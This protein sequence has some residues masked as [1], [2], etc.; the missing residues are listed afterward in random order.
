MLA[1][2]STTGLALV[3]GL[4]GFAPPPA[5]AHGDYDGDHDIDNADFA[6]LAGC[7]AGPGAGLGSGCGAFD[8]D[9]DGD[10]DLA[11]FAVFQQ[12]F[13]TAPMVSVPG[14]SFWMGDP[15]G[16]GDADEQPAH[17]VY[18]SPYYIDTYEVTNQQYVAA[19]NWARAQGALITV[20]DGRVYRY[21]G[22]YLYCETT[23][24]DSHSRITWDPN[25]DT[26]GL[27]PGKESHPIL[28]VSWYGAVA[29]CNWRSAMEGKPLCYNLSTW[30]CTFPLNGYRLPTEAEWEKAAAWDPVSERHYRFGEHTDG[31]GVDCLDGHR[32]NYDASGDPYE[33]PSYPDTTPV[34]F[35]NGALHYK[36][37][38]GWPA[39]PT[40]YQT[41]DAQSYYGC[42][43]MSGNVREWC[44]DWY[45]DTYYSSP[46]GPDPT[47][48]TSGTERVLRGG[49]WGDQP[50]ACRSADRARLGPGG[51]NSF[52]G[53]RCA[54]GR[55]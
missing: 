44:N 27:V 51:A 12:F 48:P 18:V 52:G 28:M 35:Y 34:G 9:W 55:P 49:C 38:F 16:E 36:A 8:F 43:D 6:A 24:S 30:S 53:F 22:G 33:A 42:Y 17:A 54:V 19:L 41:Q 4:G 20:T 21:S 3:I 23:T 45:S 31:C 25:T 7:L 11:D 14:G 40:S 39:S 46:S 2:Y 1:R 26:F 47:G 5:T 32:A 15:N 50:R 37:D 13:A 29:F 10:A